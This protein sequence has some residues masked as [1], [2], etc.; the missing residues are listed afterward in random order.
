[1][2][3]D[4]P[5]LHSILDKICE[6]APIRGMERVYLASG[7]PNWLD[8]GVFAGLECYIAENNNNKITTTGQQQN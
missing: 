1:M 5:L 6:K 4:Y 2:I 3:A 8:S 7:A